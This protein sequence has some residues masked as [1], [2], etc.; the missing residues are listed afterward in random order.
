MDNDFELIKNLVEE[1]VW[2]NTID[3]IKHQVNEYVLHKSWTVVDTLEEMVWDNVVVN[4]WNAVEI[5]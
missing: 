3:R 5:P 1:P 2:D 4:I